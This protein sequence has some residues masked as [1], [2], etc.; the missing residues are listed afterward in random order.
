MNITVLGFD[1]SDLN[2]YQIREKAREYNWPCVHLDIK[3]LLHGDGKLLVY[4]RNK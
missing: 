4:R 2:I 3:R 1:A